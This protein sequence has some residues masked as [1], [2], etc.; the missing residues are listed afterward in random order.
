MGVNVTFKSC[1]LTSLAWV[2]NQETCASAPR[3]SAPPVLSVAIAVRAQDG[4][5]SA[6]IGSRVARPSAVQVINA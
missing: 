3:A 1:S 6:E 5:I 4:F 2:S